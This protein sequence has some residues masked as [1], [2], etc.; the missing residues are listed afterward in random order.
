MTGSLFSWMEIPVAQ[1]HTV[2]WLTQDAYDRLQRE[3]AELSGPARVEIAKKIEA[4]RAEGDLKENSGYHAAKDEQGKI[5]ARIRD[6]TKILKTA[7]VGEA[8]V[9]TGV[10][11]PGTIITATILG[12]Q[13]TFLLGSREIAVDSEYTVY[14]ESSPLGTAIIGM[15][16]GVTVS[17]EAPSGKQIHVEILAVETFPG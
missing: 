4:A 8:P 13:T 16:V 15:E 7:T 9:S 10:V 2:G 11:V 5:E 14:S 1:E 17:Y 3:L 12:E 6:L